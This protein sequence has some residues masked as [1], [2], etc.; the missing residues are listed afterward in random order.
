MWDTVKDINIHVTGVSKGEERGKRV[1][2]I[3]EEITTEYF[4][5]LIENITLQNWQTGSELSSIL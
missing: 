3:L 5:S 2:K 1:G 4:S